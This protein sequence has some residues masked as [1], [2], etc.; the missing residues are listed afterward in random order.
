MDI[1]NEVLRRVYLVAAVVLGVAMLIFFRAFKISQVE[2]DKWRKK[3]SEEYIKL[4]PVQAERGNI[5]AADG[6][7]LATSLPFYDIWF[8][9]N[10]TG[11]SEQEFINQVDSLA[12]CITKHFE[13]GYTRY[14]YADFLKQK[15]RKGS[16]NVL[17]KKNATQKELDL[18]MSF[19]LF[20]LGR[21]KGG[22][23]V[24]RYYKRF[25]PLNMLAHRTI[26]Y[27]RD[28]LAKPIG[29][30]GSYNQY[31][32]GEVGQRLM[33]KAGN[34]YLPVNDLSEVDP[35][36]GDD[37][38]TTLDTRMQEHTENALLRA[39]EYHNADWGTAIVMETNTGAIKAIANLGRTR[40]NDLWET[41]NY[42]IGNAA[43]PGST[44][45]LAS[46]M[47]LL[48]DKE[49]E[50]DDSLRI[51]KGH[52]KF[53]NQEML[54]A[55]P[56]NIDSTSVRHVFEMSSNVGVASLINNHFGKNKTTAEKFVQYLKN[57]G[58]DKPTGID[59][60][61]EAPS[62][63][64]S[65]M[66]NDELW[67][68]L[69]L[70]WMSI[71]YEALVTPIQTLT[72]YNAVA[73]DGKMMKPYLVSEVRRD[74]EVLENFKPVVLKRKIASSK[75]ID[76]V[77]EL[78]EG[79]VER[80]TAAK[81]KSDRFQFAGKTGTAQV[82]YQKITKKGDL[83]YRSSFVGYFPAD[84]PKYTIMVMISNPKQYGLYGAEVALPVFREIADRCYSTQPDL[85]VAMNQGPADAM[86][87]RQLPRAQA[88]LRTDF[89]HVISSLKLP[90]GTQGSRRKKDEAPQAKWVV[91]KATEDHQLA[92]SNRKINKKL[93]P[94]VSGMG[95][96]DAL[97]LLENAGC[98]VLVTGTGKVQK[99]SVPPGTKVNGQTVRILLQ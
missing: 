93:V 22:L 45:K 87:Y 50:L 31:L 67:S 41:Y 85:V 40:K 36:N 52:R 32:Q 83:H 11:M 16:R 8:D 27:V 7:I 74:G 94:N 14:G 48:E 54:D 35:R 17:I 10:S 78:L 82:N 6:S 89:E 66:D 46:M 20:N 80:G 29:L 63:I 58:L 62:Y 49:V 92:L 43:E 15:R 95:L 91:V 18:I 60:D 88:G 98:R 25:T 23:V 99:Q 65:P 28:S 96:R 19:P 47:A 51:Y 79:V 71:G 75:T 76:K 77:K 70:P 90:E 9:P 42:A 12:Y 53:F 3:A 13:H 33:Q 37:I 30:E 81:L 56:H 68:G 84:A 55:H 97:Y 61:G 69:T 1:K 44:F 73:N 2:G 72:L 5:L 26:G 4:M 39:L 59:L 21:Y 86:T 57:F 34:I 64:K 38:V 24:D